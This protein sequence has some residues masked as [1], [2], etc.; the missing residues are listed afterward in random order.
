MTHSKFN[1]GGIFANNLTEMSVV[2]LTDLGSRSFGCK[3]RCTD[4]TGQIF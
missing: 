2:Q 3:L 4:P 1:T